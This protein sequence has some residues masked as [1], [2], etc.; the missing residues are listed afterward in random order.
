MKQVADQLDNEK[1]FLSEG[2][3]CYIYIDLYLNF[4]H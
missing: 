2:P 1:L 4:D 3:I